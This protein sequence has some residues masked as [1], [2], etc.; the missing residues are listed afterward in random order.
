MTRAFPDVLKADAARIAQRSSF[1]KVP[2]R[3]LTDAMHYAL[4]GGK[5]LRGFL[6]LESSRLHDVPEAAALQAALAIECL[7]G[8]SLIHDDLPCM[9]DDDMRRG[10]PTVHRKW[11]EATAVLAGDALQTLAFRLL[12]KPEIADLEAPVKYAA[13]HR[14]TEGLAK[15]SGDAGMVLGQMLDMEAEAADAPLSLREIERLQSLKTGALLLWSATAGPVMAGAET[16]S[17]HKYGQKLGLAFQ[18]W[19]DVL[20]VEG[21]A[22]EVG[23]AVGKDA[24]RGKATFVSH[25]GLDGAKRRAG[26]IVTEACDALSVYGS[27]AECL[28]QAAR[29]VISRRN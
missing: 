3:P 26:E 14:L 25:L 24:G 7:H 8:Y 19:D 1:L 9:D 13:S 21:D 4:E 17:L 23:K 5:M 2:N 6:V 11:D 28:R 20:D 15:A 22:A 29:F 27:K 18:I 12:T 10:R 16:G